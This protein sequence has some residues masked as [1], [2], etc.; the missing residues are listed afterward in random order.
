MLEN[1]IFGDKTD[2]AIELG[3]TKT[4]GKYKLCFWVQGKKMGSFT[5]AGEL[6]SS[7]KAY[8]TFK[9]NKERFYL[10]VFDKMS[11]TQI[12]NYLVTDLFT[13][14]RSKKTD[15]IEDYER[16]QK[17]YLFFGLQF[18]ND[19]CDI[20][21]IYKDNNVIFIYSPPKTTNADSYET[22]FDNFCKV[23]DEYIEYVI[24]NKI[25]L[26]LSDIIR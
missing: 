20:L 8:N 18:A 17:F 26:K 19:G 3:D 21:P 12:A 14:G 9:E 6:S 4:A 11:P 2:F 7:I 5:R 25:V 10:S 15:K 13:L 16:R 22:T 23:F 1:K 24:K